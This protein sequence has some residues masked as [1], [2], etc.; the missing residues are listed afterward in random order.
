MNNVRAALAASLPKVSV[1][2]PVGIVKPRPI[3]YRSIAEIQIP[4]DSRR[5]AAEGTDVSAPEA[6]SSSSSEQ[7][8]VPS[9]PSTPH[10]QNH[11][12]TPDNNGKENFAKRWAKKGRDKYVGL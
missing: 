5:F 4:Y 7:T 8:Q 3:S 11:D 12:N 10:D 9:Q 2:K 6:K 1:E